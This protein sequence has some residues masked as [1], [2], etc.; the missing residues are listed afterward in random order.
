MTKSWDADEDLVLSAEQLDDKYN[1][2]GDGEHP[3]FQRCNWRQAVMQEETVC[4]YWD[5]VVRQVYEFV[6]DEDRCPHGMF[7]SGAGA[8]PCCER[9]GK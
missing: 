6:T 3:L 1:P 5:W 2:E 4:G 8:C 7:Y 9:G